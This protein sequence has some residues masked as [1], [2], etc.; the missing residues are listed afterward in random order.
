[1]L[2]ILEIFWLSVATISF[3]YGIYQA[4]VVG[5]MDAILLFGITII[6]LLVYWLRHKQRLRT[7]KHNL[8]KDIL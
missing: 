4:I 6:S 5:P 2:K 7:E 3:F 8:N 1:M